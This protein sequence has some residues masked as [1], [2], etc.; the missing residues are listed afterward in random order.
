MARCI[1]LLVLIGISFTYGWNSIS[2]SILPGSIVQRPTDKP[3]DKPI[4]IVVHDGGKYCYAPVFI[5]GESYIQ[6]GGCGEQEVNNA[7]Y[8]VFQRISYYINDTW[9]CI[10]APEKVVQGATDWDYVNLRP[11]TINDSLQRWIVKDHSFWTADE[12]YRLKD[13]NWYAYIS[14]N[15]KDSYDHTLDSSMDDWVKTVATPGNVSIKTSIAWYSGWGDGIL[16]MPPSRYFIYVEGS[17]KN[18]TPIYYNPENGHLAQYMPVSGIFLCMHSQVG[19]YNWNWVRWRF[20]SDASTSSKDN[21]AYWNVYLTTTE[22]GGMIT[23]YQGNIL[24]VTKSGPNWGVAYAVK[25]SY[26]KNDTTNNPTS[27]FFVD[28]DLLNWVR[29]TAGNLGKT[30]QYCPAGNKES[31]NKRIRRTL[32]SNF[33]LTEEWMRRLY[34]IAISTSFTDPGQIH[35]ICGVCLLHT[36]Q[37]LAEL[38][39]YHS[40]GPLQSGG[41]FF[42]TAPNRDPFDSF[43]QRY[44]LLD[45]M[46]TDAATVYGP[47]YNTTR[48]LTLVSA[49]TMLPQY[50]WTPSNEFTRRSDI[51]SHI[52]SLID[53]P[54][55]SI[56]LGLM[57]RRE[58]DQTLGWHAL[59]ILRTSQGL[60]VIPT[61][62]S[63]ISFDLYR[64]YLT[65]STSPAQ[66]INDYLEEADRTLTVFVT[67]QLEQ[68]YQNLFDFMISN[69]NC[70][71]EGEDRR[72]TG[73]YPTSA[74]VNQCSKGRCALP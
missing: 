46:L 70:T 10:T 31:H 49:M 19:S 45:T 48:L 21:S 54:P 72:G 57:Q 36:F 50:E 13:I 47:A 9:L 27:L 1:V 68:A 30:E 34:D 73:G 61:R 37:M 65:P 74:T 67:I 17:D 42:D 18:T 62:V 66:I 29:Y 6:I 69:R 55:G 43:R 60:V 63:S 11:C 24:R 8:D 3:K 35:G 41:Y 23:D 22:E 26:L 7:R 20:C 59:P 38:Q 5:R 64:E 56:W 39:E 32:P 71:G 12:R 40:Q 15:S 16:D 4:K 2:S 44:P 28:S 14:K 33:Q 51:H 58:S 25:P 53:S 52:R